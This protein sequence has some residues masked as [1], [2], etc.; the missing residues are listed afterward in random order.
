MHYAVLHHIV[1]R[2]RD[3]SQFVFLPGCT[4]TLACGSEVFMIALLASHSYTPDSSDVTFSSVRRDPFLHNHK[5]FGNISPF[6][7]KY[8]VM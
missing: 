6:N 8:K 3:R 7:N 1:C 4:R 2:G 5:F